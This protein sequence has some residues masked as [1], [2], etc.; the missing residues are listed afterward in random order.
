MA[1]GKNEV[2]IDDPRAMRALAHPARL[3][4]IDRLYAGEVATATELAEGN[5]LSPSA[6]S[7][8]L[9]ELEKWGVIEREPAGGDGRERRWRAAGDG[10]QIGSDRQHSTAVT[11]AQMAVTGQILDRM[12]RSLDSFARVADE[13]PA[14]WRTAPSVT[15]SNLLMTPAELRAFKA[16]LRKLLDRYDAKRKDVPEQ[17]RRVRSLFAITPTVEDRRRKV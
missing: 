8:H 4:A 12:R 16:D 13:E 14:P 1:K 17:A 11:A 6:M 15:A 9:R 10:L 7:Y 5:D 2:V 3:E